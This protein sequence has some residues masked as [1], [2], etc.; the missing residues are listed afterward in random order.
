MVFS[1]RR[2]RLR[3]PPADHLLRYV[4]FGIV[5]RIVR[6][7]SVRIPTVAATAG[8]VVVT[9]ADE[10]IETTGSHDLRRG[11]VVLVDEEPAR[12]KERVQRLR[13]VELPVPV[14]GDD[15]QIAVDASHLVQPQSGQAKPMVGQSASELRVL[16]PGK[17]EQVADGRQRQRES[18]S[19]AFDQLLA[20]LHGDRVGLRFAAAHRLQV[21]DNDRKLDSGRCVLEV[22]AEGGTQIGN[23]EDV[24]DV[25]VFADL[26]HL[27]ALVDQEA[28]RLLTVVRLTDIGCVASVVAHHR[29]ALG[30]HL[31]VEHDVRAGDDA[32]DC[33]GEEIRFGLVEVFPVLLTEHDIAIHAGNRNV[34][35]RTFDFSGDHVRVG[36]SFP[37]AIAA[38]AATAAGAS[39]LRTAAV[40]FG[41]VA[42]TTMVEAEQVIRVFAVA[43]DHD[44]VSV[45][46]PER[47]DLI[48][49]ELGVRRGIGRTQGVDSLG[50]LQS[51]LD[52]CIALLL[53]E[54][55]IAVLVDLSHNGFLL[56]DL[57]ATT[58]GLLC[59]QCLQR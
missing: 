34:G 51:A 23:A 16:E 57:L 17:H 35:E 10:A 58:R 46:E 29:V 41:L 50:V 5:R 37:A 38:P 47:L 31:D 13:R 12:L 44:V 2:A 22:E 15:D 28:D 7:R 25:R 24:R 1:R 43:N 8:G 42:T 21:D 32:V 6:K 49:G 4:N 59:W 30:G 27:E 3:Y 19:E 36:K 48:E 45:G 20:L 56:Q 54:D 55:D 14:A 40:L 39:L 11:L 18:A 9:V 53:R 33:L 52:E 26:Q